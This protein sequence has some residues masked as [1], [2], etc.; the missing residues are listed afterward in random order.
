MNNMAKILITVIFFVSMSQQS[1]GSASQKLQELKNLNIKHFSSIVEDGGIYKVIVFYEANEDHAEI[2][3]DRKKLW[4]QAKGVVS[5]GFK[6]FEIHSDKKRQRLWGIFIWGKG[7]H[8]EQVQVVDLKSG[9]ALLERTSSW[10]VLLAKE[11]NGLTLTSYGD[12]I[13]DNKF[14]EVSDSLT[15]D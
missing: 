4:E 13:S 8:G 5:T 10:P 9:K 11:A 2:Y 7:V 14:K 15:F 6:S 3:K 1:Y 12:R